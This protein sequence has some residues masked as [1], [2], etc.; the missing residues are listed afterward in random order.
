M[1]LKRDTAE[2]TFHSAWDDRD[3]WRLAT[4][5]SLH[6]HTWNSKE[7][8]GFLPGT[9][10]RSR[11]L[12]GLL[13]RL[14]ASFLKKWKTP[15]DYDR[16]YWTSP[17]SPEAAY[18]LETEQI[19]RHGMQALVSITDHD[20]I[21]GC[22]DIVSLEWTVPYE[23]AIFHVGVHHLPKAEASNY[24]AMVKNVTANPG[25]A[26]VLKHALAEID[27]LPNSLI[28]LN[29]P[30][31]DQGRIGR[32]IHASL[33]YDFLRTY[34]SYVHAL[35]INGLQPWSVNQRVFAIAN[36]FGLPLVAG[37]D[38]HGF[39]PNGAINVTNA[40]TFDDFASEIRKEKKSRIVLMPQYR[41]P[42]VVRYTTNAETITADY[43]EL[44][45]RVH[46]HD[47]VFYHCP[48]GVTRPVTDMVAKS[49]SRMIATTNVTLGVLR[50]VNVLAR[51]IAPLFSQ[52]SLAPMAR[53]E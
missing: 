29:H 36:D 46:W 30:L 42:L 18:A 4:G 26:A 11:I 15:L 35:E 48:D 39:E 25:D 41:E 9:F 51:P 23:S 6:G 37:G 22:D 32:E 45:G 19:A 17:V 27:S 43:P 1:A 50:S 47:R 8:L 13:R 12:T 34:G 21:A 10:A 20:E 38:R 2:T 31:V 28:V 40:E 33:V 5:V 52:S 16:G 49:H 7:G 44:A 53:V 3:D 24:L 14:E